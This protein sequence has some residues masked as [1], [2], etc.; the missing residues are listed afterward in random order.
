MPIMG[1]IFASRVF[2]VIDLGAG[3]DATD[4]P[5]WALVEGV[6]AM[7]LAAAGLIAVGAGLALLAV[8]L[9]RRKR[10]TYAP[11]SAD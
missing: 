11:S 6:E 1:A 7:Y 4:A 2:A 5:P 3:V 9:D 10:Q 8:V